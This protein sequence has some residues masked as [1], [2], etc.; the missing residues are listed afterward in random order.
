MVVPLEL[1]TERGDLSLF[2][3]TT[4]FGT[5]IDVTLSE[6]AIEEF[7]PAD[8][9]SADALRLLGTDRPLRA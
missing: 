7:Y 8:R 9:A 5:P 1:R 3:T 4:V 6:L 2:S